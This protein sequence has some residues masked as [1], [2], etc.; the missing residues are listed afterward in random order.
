MTPRGHRIVFSR[1]ERRLLRPPGVSPRLRPKNG[2]AGSGFTL[3][4]LLVV[5]AI[6][7][8]L[9]ALLLPALQRAKAAG[10]RAGCLNNL[11]QFVVANVI[12]AGDNGDQ[13]VPLIELRP[14]AATQIWMAN[15]EFRKL[16]GY[17]RKVPRQQNLWVV[18][19]SG[20]RPN[21]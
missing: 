12:Y 4:E 20:S 16:I 14:I 13:C 3:I 9:A 21:V 17:D 11:H 7:A 1:Q 8:I 6:M 5:I 19:G 10:H 18:S 2:A 15:Q